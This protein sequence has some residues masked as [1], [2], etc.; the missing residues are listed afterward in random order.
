MLHQNHHPSLVQEGMI[1]GLPQFVW[2]LIWKVQ[3]PYKVLNF[4]WKMLHGSLP[5]FE[6]LNKRGI[7][8]PNNCHMCNE[9]E[10]SINHLFL[11]YPFARAIWYGSNLE[12]TTLDLVHNSVTHWLASCI[13]RNVNRDNDRMFFLQSIFTILWSIWNHRNTV[14]HQGQLPNPIEVI[15]TSWSLTCRYQEVFQTN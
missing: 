7:T 13:L 14:L 15:L 2:N 6:V 5:V 4:I 8:I 9:E 3:L 1:H 10:E 12:V 11:H